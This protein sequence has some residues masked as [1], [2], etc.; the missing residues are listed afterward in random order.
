MLHWCCVWMKK[1]LSFF[2]KK[3]LTVYCFSEKKQLGAP[4]TCSIGWQHKHWTEMLE[5][6]QLGDNTTDECN[7]DWHGNSQKC[8]SPIT[9]LTPPWQSTNKRVKLYTITI[10]IWHLHVIFNNFYL[11]HLFLVL[12]ID[13]RSPPW[14]IFC[15]STLSIDTNTLIGQESSRY[16][17]SRGQELSRD[18]CKIFLGPL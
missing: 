9:F 3:F 11:P 2:L 5:H 15:R 10:F 14:H 17:E 1:T 4:S 7:G 16:L 8:F 13:S 12:S 6:A 18:M